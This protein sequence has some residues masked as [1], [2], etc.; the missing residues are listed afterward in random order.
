MC[1]WTVCV[2]AGVSELSAIFHL[3]PQHP[4]VYFFHSFVLSQ[5]IPMMAAPV[6]FFNVLAW[7]WF[8]YYSLLYYYCHPPSAPSRTCL[9]FLSVVLYR[10]NFFSSS[11]FFSSLIYNHFSFFYRTVYNNFFPLW[12]SSINIIYIYIDYEL[13]GCYLFLDRF[14]PLFFCRD[15]TQTERAIAVFQTSHC[16]ALLSFGLKEF[17]FFRTG[18]SRLTQP[19]W[20]WWHRIESC[21]SIVLFCFVVSLAFSS[22]NFGGCIKY[23]R[24][25]NF[26]F[27]LNTWRKATHMQYSMVR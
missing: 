18:I 4:F 23:T 15:G 24:G 3:V 26:C 11:P 2:C 19:P 27:F 22:F 25:W 12:S 10:V 7:W 21:G 20:F 5:P 14:V 17:I 1:R 13:Y 9:S 6:F 8:S 16:I